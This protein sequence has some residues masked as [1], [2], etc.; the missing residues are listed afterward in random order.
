MVKS[1]DRCFIA[2]PRARHRALVVLAMAFP[3]LLAGYLGLRLEIAA[4]RA[5][6]PQGILVLG[7]GHQRE[8]LA[9]ELGRAHPELP[10]WVS[11]GI[12]RARSCPIFRAAGIADERVRRDYSALDTVGNFTTLVGDVAA[13]EVEH[14]YVVTNDYHQPRAAAIATVVLGSRGIT[15]TFAT[16]PRPDI[17]PESG[18]ERARDI[19]RALGWLLLGGH[20]PAVSPSTACPPAEANP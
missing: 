15:F 18:Y 6:A 4:T 11:S 5:P 10:I 14:L 19:I 12:A 20:A 8:R 16:Y 7:G 9:A 3:A 17:P 2:L 13:A 1:R